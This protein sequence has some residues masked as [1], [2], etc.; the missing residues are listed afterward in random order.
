MKKLR[1]T[2][3]LGLGLALGAVA[4]A[5]PP[6]GLMEAVPPGLP[7]RLAP[8]NIMVV[9]HDQ[10]LLD[11]Y[12][13]TTLRAHLGIVGDA[14]NN[15]AACVINIDYAIFRS[16]LL[17]AVKAAFGDEI[18]RELYRSDVFAEAGVEDRP[19]KELTVEEK[20]RLLLAVHQYKEERL[21]L[22][23]AHKEGFKRCLGEIG[24]EVGLVADDQFVTGRAPEELDERARVLYERQLE[25]IWWTLKHL[26]V[27]EEED[28][29]S[30]SAGGLCS[31]ELDVSQVRIR[32]S[33]A[34]DAERLRE[35]LLYRTIVGDGILWDPTANL[36][37]FLLPGRSWEEVGHDRIYRS[38]P[39]QTSSHSISPYVLKRGPRTIM[40]QAFLPGT[41]V[42]LETM[43]ESVVLSC[44]GS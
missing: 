5:P 21:E 16:V 31:E 18:L 24:V 32:G 2:L 26:P 11:F 27:G 29:I 37:Q 1:A 42:V 38:C 41:D 13:L 14:Q 23:A 10:M 8:P 33:L 15:A 35:Q 44:T 19:S 20:G 7:D 40:M 28:S 25:A 34:R 3:F 39:R 43:V 4:E 12:S 9:M 22:L 6:D 17:E 30:V 36:C